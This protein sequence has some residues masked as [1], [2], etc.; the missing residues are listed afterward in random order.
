VCSFYSSPLLFGNKK[1][2]QSYREDGGAS[3]RSW[4]EEWGGDSKESIKYYILK[5][6]S[7]I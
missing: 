7:C 6:I 4:G 5:T 3:E 1:K 2:T